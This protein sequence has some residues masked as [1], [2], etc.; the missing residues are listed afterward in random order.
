[1]NYGCCL[2]SKGEYEKAL[3]YF[4]QALVTAPAMATFLSIWPLRKNALE[5][6]PAEVEADF[7]KAL[8]YSAGYHGSYFFYARWL[9]QQ[10]RD[11]EAVPLLI[12]TIQLSPSFMEARYL[13]MDIYTRERQWKDL[14]A[15]AKETLKIDSH[16]QQALDYLKTC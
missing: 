7:R 11:T 12:K 2:M 10:K 9:D 13:L 16:D 8:E 6:A 4:E 5:R 3:S 1:M 15:L 14:S